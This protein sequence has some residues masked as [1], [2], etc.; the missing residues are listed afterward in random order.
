MTLLQTGDLFRSRYLI[1]GILGQGGMGI[2][3]DAYD[4]EQHRPCAIKLLLSHREESEQYRQRLMAEIEIMSRLDHPNIVK[5]Y[6]FFGDHE[7]IRTNGTSSHKHDVKSSEQGQVPYLVM[8]RL[9][10]QSLA[11]LLKAKTLNLAKAI[12]IIQQTLAAIAH[13]HELGIIHR[14]LKPENLFLAHNTD[15]ELRLKVLDF[16]VAKD[17]ESDV[18]LTASLD[19]PLIGTPHYMA[20]EQ[21]K[22][23][24]VAPSCDLYS[25]GVILYEMFYAHPPFATSSLELPSELSILPASFKLT[26][27]HLHTPPPP[28]NFEKKLDQVIENLLA[29][30]PKKRPQS[31]NELSIQLEQWVHKNVTLLKLNLPIQKHTGQDL[32][33][34]IMTLSLLTAEAQREAIKTIKLSIPVDPRLLDKSPPKGVTQSFCAS[35]IWTNTEDSPAKETVPYLVTTKLKHAT[36]L[37]ESSVIL[38]QLTFKQRIGIK[39]LVSFIILISFSLI[40][41]QS[42]DSNPKQTQHKTLNQKHSLS[43]E[44]SDSQAN[45]QILTQSHNNI[46][47]PEDLH[48]LIVELSKIE[49]YQSTTLPKHIDQSLIKRAI[50]WLEN[51]NLMTNLKTSLR[52]QALLYQAYLYTWFHH[53]SSS[54]HALI[55]LYEIKPKLLNTHQEQHLYALTLMRINLPTSAL[56]RLKLGI[57]HFQIADRLFFEMPPADRSDVDQHHFYT[58]LKVYLNTKSWSLIKDTLQALQKVQKL[59]PYMTDLLLKARN[60]AKLTQK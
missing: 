46:K 55:K 34:Q 14:D 29:K 21:I 23:Q 8:E 52:Y 6:D 49:P 36:N 45:Y 56:R 47:A 30:D 24:K 59:D 32:S 20:P 7:T 3:Y 44:Q 48:N 25:V 33:E 4:Q 9:E 35:A 28:L 42:L 11:E 15:S 58:R 22:N 39:L 57:K 43:V 26:W 17:L 12:N 38:G 54:K 16:G 50:K 18:S 10:G 41:F 53:K 5:I 2:V 60:Q 1:K 27:L 40:V 19:F 37:R 13:A 51:S 31:A